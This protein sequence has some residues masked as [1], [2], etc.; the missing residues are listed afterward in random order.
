MCQLNSIHSIQFQPT[1]TQAPAHL[2]ISM[3]TAGMAIPAYHYIA[4]NH[5]VK[6]P[7]H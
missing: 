2:R 1:M 4:P 6:S 5:I 3:E 7:I